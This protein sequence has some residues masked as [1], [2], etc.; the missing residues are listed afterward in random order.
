MNITVRNM[1]IDLNSNIPQLMLGVL[2]FQGGTVCQYISAAKY[3]IILKPVVRCAQFPH[4]NTGGTQGH[5]Q[6]VRKK[7]AEMKDRVRD[8]EMKTQG[9]CS[10]TTIFVILISGH[11]REWG[12]AISTNWLTD[13]LNAA[14]VSYNMSKME[15][16]LEIK[17]LF[18]MD[19]C[20]RLIR[21]IN[22][23]RKIFEI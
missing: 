13:N 5:T 6:R 8:E 18:S 7:R 16:I 14:Y 17:N 15:R 11:P 20:S 3:M 12:R 1:E 10:M 2:F 21:R 9:R 22:R 19:F 4:T 23:R